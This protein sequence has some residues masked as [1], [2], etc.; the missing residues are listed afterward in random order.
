MTIKEK[1]IVLTAQDVRD[2]RL[3]DYRKSELSWALEMAGYQLI[4][5]GPTSK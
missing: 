5:E 4:I 3:G 2:A 1:T